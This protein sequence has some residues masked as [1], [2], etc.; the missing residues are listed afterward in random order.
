[1]GKR[2][3]TLS[4][5]QFF[6][7]LVVGLLIALLGYFLRMQ[8][9]YFFPPVGDTQDELKAVFNGINLI[10]TGRPKS[11]S[12]LTE[13][14][15]S[16]VV[17]IRNSEF[18]LVDPWLDEPP[19]FSLISGR[20]ALSKG[21]TV[22]ESVDAG[23]M[24]W[25]M[26]KLAAL[27]IFLLF[28]LI[29]LLRNIYEALLG[30]VIFATEPTMVIGSRLPISENMITMVALTSLVLLTLYLR[31]THWLI[32][33]LVA[34]I[35]SSAFLMKTTGIFVPVTL[36]ILLLAFHKFKAG[37]I[38]G[39]FM[40]LSILIWIFYGMHYDWNLFLKLLPVFSGRELTSP[41]MI[42][43]LFEVFRIG[44][45]AMSV[46]GWMI[47]GWI[48][49]V[50]YSFLKNNDNKNLLSRIML[51]VAVG[52][53]LT[54]FTIMSGHM[55][56]WYRFP[57]YPFLSWAIAAV[58]IEIV[59]NPRFLTTFFF[60]TIPFFASYISGNGN[61]KWTSNDVKLFQPVFVSSMAIPML[62]E[63]FNVKQL[64]LATQIV[65][66]VLFITAIIFNIRTI[67]IYQSQFWY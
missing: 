54:F 65:L 15:E 12:W 9:F 39:C 31:K 57:F 46:D 24:R 19:L 5:T 14:G 59:K 1:M 28:L 4:N 56:G 43:N 50:A 55:K 35:G 27:N 30:A 41:N 38:V 10:Q 23:A 58:F 25:P 3:L 61:P 6:L 29:Y 48:C 37:I 33:I 66:I 44:E 53:Y 20:Y 52:T 26:L 42:I 32:L 51:P 13:Y 62:Y 67:L 34:V 2:L 17:H 64:K 45:K 60:T 16:K 49:V 40:F 47:W 22:L 21:M 8:E 7:V 11:W 36:I 18:K 63:V